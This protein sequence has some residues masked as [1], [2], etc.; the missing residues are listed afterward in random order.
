MET[1]FVT[2]W[3]YFDVM[4]F[5]ISVERNL[6]GSQ[7]KFH[8]LFYKIS[9]VLYNHAYQWAL[10]LTLFLTWY[11]LKNIN[12]LSLNCVVMLLW[13]MLI[14]GN[15]TTMSLHFIAEI[16]MHVKWNY[17]TPSWTHLHENHS[18]TLWF[19]QTHHAIIKKVKFYKFSTLLSVK[20]VNNI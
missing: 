20:A 6:I 1:L 19:T 11:F 10:D 5:H 13:K 8:A 18:E 4:K 3:S 2:K 12:Y 14:F 9:C 17:N 7:M 15:L 16:S